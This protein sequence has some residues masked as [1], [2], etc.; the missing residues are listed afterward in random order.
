MN[1]GLAALS[2]LK[3]ILLSLLSEAFLEWLFFWVGQM[4]VD[5]TKTTKDDE[6]LRKVKEVYKGSKEV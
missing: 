4:L 1:I 6:F 2:V 3:K 5:S